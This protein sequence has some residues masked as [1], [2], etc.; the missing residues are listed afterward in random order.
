[1]C[2]ERRNKKMASKKSLKEQ[3]SQYKTNI[4]ETLAKSVE[5]ENGNRED[6]NYW[7]P[8]IKD[9]PKKIRFVPTADGDPFKMLFFHY[10]KPRLEGHGGFLCLKKNYNAKCPLCEFANK[11]WQKYEEGDKTE[12]G[13]K[14]LFKGFAAGRQPR[15]FAPVLVRGEEEKGVR[16]WGFSHT[17]WN[18]LKAIM[19]DPD[20]GDIT[21][22]FEGTDLTVEVTKPKA[23]SYQE[24][25]IRPARKASKLIEDEDMIMDLLK[26][27]PDFDDLHKRLSA[28]EMQAI[29]DE[30]YDP[31]F[32]Q[33]DG[34]FERTSTVEEIQEEQE[35]Q[36]SVESVDDIVKQLQ[37]DAS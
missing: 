37:E 14:D 5:E 36:E 6:P 25:D 9:G 20:Y 28:K 31:D 30:N 27:I 26:T 11:A 17:V 32:F 22:I 15:V 21:D 7:R 3:L 16:W 33:G 10:P 1:M 12:D 2:P 24:T 18:K 8:T 35:N 23:N 19:R 4:N 34:N 13:W 29:I